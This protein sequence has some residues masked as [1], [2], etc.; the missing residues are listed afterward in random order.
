MGNVLCINPGHV[1]RGQ[2][3]GSYAKL[4][5][6]RKDARLLSETFETS[7][8]VDEADSKSVSIVNHAFGSVHRILL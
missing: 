3:F 7:L 4:V 2:V 8:D 5:I 6:T 1:S